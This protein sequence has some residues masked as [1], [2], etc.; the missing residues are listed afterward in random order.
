MRRELSISDARGA[1]PCVGGYL[2]HGSLFFFVIN[3]APKLQGVHDVPNFIT[4]EDVEIYE[5][6][7]EP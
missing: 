5:S 6:Y 2:S 7:A 3:V 4:Q 1:F